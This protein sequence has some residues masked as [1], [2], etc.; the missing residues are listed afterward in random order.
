MTGPRNRALLAWYRR[1]GRT[2]PWRETDDPY[3]RLVS[4]VMLQQ[5]QVARVIPR[6][7]TFLARFP[8]VEALA[9]APLGQVLAEWSGLGYY[10][11]AVNLHRAARRVAE[12]GWPTTAR[13]LRSLPGVGP[14]T[15]SALACFSFGEQVAAV[16]TNLR[17]VLSRWQ[18]R[19]LQGSELGNIASSE[20]P[21]GEASPWN[22]AVMDLGASICTPRKPLCSE[23]P[24]RRWCA[25]PE[26]SPAAAPRAAYE[27]STRQARGAIIHSLTTGPSSCMS[28]VS[29]TGLPADRIER[30][31]SSLVDEGLVEVEGNW[32]RLP[33]A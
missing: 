11:R 27:G 29:R 14:Y 21:A 9:A 3:P 20:L 10:R 6:Y 15:A 26:A 13:E 16:D 22:Q 33:T 7:G 4:E 32:Y 12:Q 23:C 24:V 2:L 18:G 1:R 25:G 5:T 30:A 28:L 17:R 8:T 31:L 19:P